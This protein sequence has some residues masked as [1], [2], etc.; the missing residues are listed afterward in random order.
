MTT[1]RK[2]WKKVEAV[3]RTVILEW[4]PYGLIG[5]GA[6]ED[7]WDSEI[8]QLVG[9]VHGITTAAGAAAAISGVFSNA[10]QPEGF[11]KE[12]CGEVGRKL[13]DALKKERLI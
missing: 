11:E 4:D 5:G 6:P 9:K 7:E 3:A 13:F 8:L 1:D 12:D 2:Q 10:F